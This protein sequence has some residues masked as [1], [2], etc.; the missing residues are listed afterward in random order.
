MRIRTRILSLMSFVIFT[1]VAI[2][3]LIVYNTQ[4]EESLKSIDDRLLAAAHFA[5]SAMPADYHDRIVDQDSVSDEEYFLIV[6][7]NNKLC[8]DLNLQR[9]WSVMKLDGQVVFTSSTE[10]DYDLRT[11]ESD[12]FLKVY[13]NP[14]AFRDAFSTM[15]M[16]YSAFKNDR[17]EGRMVLVPGTDNKGRQNLFAASMSL[18]EVHALLHH[19]LMK[20]IFIGLVMLLVGVLLSLALATALSRPTEELTQAARAIAEGDFGKTVKPRGSSELKSL[21]HSVNQMSGSIRERIESLEERDS[22]LQRMNAILLGIR[23]VNQLITHEDDPVRLIEGACRNLVE[24]L[25]YQKAWIALM[26]EEATVTAI[27]SAG[28]NGSFAPMIEKLQRGELTKCGR[29]TLAWDGLIVT[30]DPAIECGGCPLSGIGE[31]RID[32]SI[33]LDHGG[34]SFGMLSASVHKTLRDDRE[35]QDLFTEVANDITFSLHRIG[36][37]K[38]NEIAGEALRKNQVQL[39]SI[40]RAAPTGIGLLVDRVLKDVNERLCEMLQYSKEEL[41]GQSV[42]MLYQNDEDYEVVGRVKYAMIQ[43]HG[44]GTVETQWRRKDGE[45]MNVLLSSTPFDIDDLSKGVTFTALDITKRKRAEEALRESEESYRALFEKMINGFACHEIICDE[46]GVPVDYRFIAANKAFERLTGLKAEEIIGKRVLEIF[47]NIEPYWIETYGKVALTGEPASFEDFS[48]ERDRTFQVIAYRPASGQ[49]ACILKDITDSKRA[50]EERLILERQVQ[51]AQKLESLGVLAGGIAHDF[52]NIL[53]AIMGNADL[54]LQELSPMAPAR[55]NVQEIEVAARRAAG[56]AKQMLAY[57]GKGR[58]VV[59]PIRLSVLV[60]EMS[61][62]LEVSISKKA[63]LKYNFADN[64][65]VFDGDATQ[66]RQIIMNLIT[67][68]SE[69]IG[70]RSGGIAISTGAMECDRDYLNSANMVASIGLSEPLAEGV[71]AYLE[72][73]DTGCGMDKETQE[74][75]FDPFF[76]TKFTGRGLGMAAVQGIIRGHLGAIKIY[77]E[78]GKGTTFK[79]LFPAAM[80]EEDSN[81]AEEKEDLWDGWQGSGTILIADDEESVCVVGKLMLERFGFSV[82]TALDGRA[83]VDVFKQNPDEVDCVLLDLTMP[84]LDGEQVFREMRRIR[85]N[86]KVILSSGYN[87]QDAT[88]RFSGKGLAGFIQKPYTSKLLAEKIREAL[89]G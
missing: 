2:F 67:N 32:M 15:E 74:K 53:M 12:S 76:T 84:H 11:T 7:R 80:D 66:I 13:K 40:F 88:Q 3:T 63:V 18:R 4:K 34:K 14:D 68:A 58:F 41:V 48:Q 27:G 30:S 23:N 64:L 81:Q 51:Q 6:D 69:A 5:K 59:E 38:E 24:T 47:P 43:E 54:A 37:E 22:R 55:N 85:A 77:S 42:R 52:N 28:F 79:V 39:Q 86:V 33:R 73:A 75:I 10:P 20:S 35:V 72:V 16:Q 83:A 89:E 49:F 1:T 9:L 45:V 8:L 82:L 21:A 65:P 60:E 19:T 62:L 31:D 26:D 17:G 71:Y 61:H 29:K 50:E 56:L 70:E 78:P 44:T 36:I 25:G 46:E 87:E 57:S